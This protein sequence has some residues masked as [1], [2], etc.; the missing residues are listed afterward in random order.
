MCFICIVA[1]LPF[2]STDKAGVLDDLLLGLLLGP[3]VGESVDD[4]T[5]NEVEDDDDDNEIEEHVVDDPEII[6]FSS[7][8]L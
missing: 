1:H 4:D 8:F 5:K 7:T 3:Q 2:K 6:S